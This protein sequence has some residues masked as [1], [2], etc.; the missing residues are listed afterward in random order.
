[1][2]STSTAAIH[3]VDFLDGLHFHLRIFD[4][5]EHSVF[6]ISDGI[7]DG[8][9]DGIRNHCCLKC[10]RRACQGLN[11]IRIGAG[12]GRLRTSS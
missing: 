5:L 12:V 7:L 9:L 1:M 2:I 6:V 3:H 11:R 4:G 8:I 10:G